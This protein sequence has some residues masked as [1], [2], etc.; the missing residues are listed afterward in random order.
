MPENISQTIV[1]YRVIGIVPN[2]LADQRFRILAIA[3][4]LRNE[5]FYNREQ[6]YRRAGVRDLLYLQHRTIIEKILAGDREGAKEA[7]AEHIRFT[8][9]TIDE[10][11]RGENRL[12]AS[13]HRVGRSELLSNSGKKSA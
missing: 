7:A 2:G 3:D 6:L 13:L 11:R 9:D 8:R 1:K 10:I 4:L 12:E 5:I